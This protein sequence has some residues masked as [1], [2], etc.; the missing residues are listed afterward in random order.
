[1]SEGEEIVR[2]GILAAEGAFIAMDDF[3][4]PGR[5][6]TFEGFSGRIVLVTLL[7]IRAFI[8]EWA[9]DDI[10]LPIFVEVTV[11]SAFGP[12]L[13]RDLNLVKGVDDVI[14]G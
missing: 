5:G 4:D 2:V 13:V 3:L 6:L 11:K 14:F 9:G 10:H 7:E 8:P 1:M 12:E